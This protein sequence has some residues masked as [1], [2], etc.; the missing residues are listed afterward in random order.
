MNISREEKKK[1]AIEIMKTLGIYGPYIEAFEKRDVVTFCEGFGGYYLTESEKELYDKVKEF[2]VEYNGVVYAIIHH[3][4]GDDECYSFL[5]IP[6]Y[7]D[8]WEYLYEPVS[9]DDDNNEFYVASYVWNKS[10]DWNSE[11][12]DI[13]VRSFGGGIKRFC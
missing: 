12:G 9:E 13:G 6:D 7:K 1:K 3:Y 11:F 8:D 4:I 5:Y 2:E 10:Y